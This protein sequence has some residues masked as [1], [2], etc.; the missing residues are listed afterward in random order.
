MLETRRWKI[1]QTGAFTLC[2]FINAMVRRMFTQ[3]QNR[4]EKEDKTELP[5]TFDVRK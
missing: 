5:W 4:E 2:M 3:N 1:C